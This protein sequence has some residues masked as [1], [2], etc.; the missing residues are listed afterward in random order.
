MCFCLLVYKHIYNKDWEP[1][2]IHSKAAGNILNALYIE[3]ITIFNSFF[4]EV[5][6]TVNMQFQHIGTHTVYIILCIAWSSLINFIISAV[7]HCSRHLGSLSYPC[8]GLSLEGGVGQIF[9]GIHFGLGQECVVWFI[10]WAESR[11]VIRL[12]SSWYSAVLSNNFMNRHVF[13]YL[14]LNNRWSNI[15]VHCRACYV[16]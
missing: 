13:W 5:H 11:G 6:C 12:I 4:K 8:A 7:K 1:P 15:L 14:N 9:W 3:R 2:S 16:Q 10:R